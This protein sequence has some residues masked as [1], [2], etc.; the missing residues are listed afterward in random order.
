MS[1]RSKP[2]KSGGSPGSDGAGLNAQE[3]EAIGALGYEEAVSRIEEII[4]RIESG[5]IGLESSLVE[6]ERGV[7]L[8]KRCREILDRAEQKV[9]ALTPTKAP[10]S[11][12][13][14]ARRDAEPEDDE[15]APF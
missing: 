14:P 10:G 4:D 7:L 6:Y 12:R 3:V 8:V 13:A 5:E 11:A 9:S 1:K 15:G 2:S